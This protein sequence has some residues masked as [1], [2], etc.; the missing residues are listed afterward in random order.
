MRGAY[1]VVLL[2]APRG[3]AAQAPPVAPRVASPTTVTTPAG[4]EPDASAEATPARPSELL[5]GPALAAAIEA[6]FDGEPSV[7]QAVAA[8]LAR[9]ELDLGRARSAAS[10][11]RR[12]GLLPTLRTSLDRRRVVGA[13]DEQAGGSAS[14]EVDR[15]DSLTVSAQLT[16]ELGRLVY[17][18]DEVAWA[19]E[20]RA[21]RDAIR[22]TT[23]EV[24]ALYY[25]RRRLVVEIE[26]FGADDLETLAALAEV[27]A[28]LE[29]FTGIHFTGTILRTDAPHDDR[30]PPPPEV[31]T[32]TRGGAHGAEGALHR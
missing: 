4:D 27:T 16:L 5:E 7:A 10:R 18:P 11:A 19:R 13:T 32:R 29:L 30:T 1:F 9:A 14:T 15:D 12:A 31:P 3:L 23:E 8:A 24:V 2:L 17:G 25:R 28:L 21:L 26:W 6:R 20:E 22:A